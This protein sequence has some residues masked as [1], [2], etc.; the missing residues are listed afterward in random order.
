MTFNYSR[1]ASATQTDIDYARINRE[2]LTLRG[3]KLMFDP[4]PRLVKNA[5]S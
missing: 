3:N 2:T 1:L 4:K 5:K